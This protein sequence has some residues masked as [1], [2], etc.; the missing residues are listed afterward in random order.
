MFRSSLRPASNVD[1]LWRVSYR[2]IVDKT[3]VA[4]YS[5][6]VDCIRKVNRPFP[7]DFSESSNSL[8]FDVERFHAQIDLMPSFL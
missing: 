2:P 8:P 1:L 7:S 6:T 3:W 4:T 5:D